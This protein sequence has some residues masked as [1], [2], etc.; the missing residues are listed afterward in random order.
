MHCVLLSIDFR[1]HIR[2]RFVKCL[3]LQIIAALVA[4]LGF[5]ANVGF[6]EGPASCL[7]G[8]LQTSTVKIGSLSI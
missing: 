4:H 1:A 8:S 3:E 5:V 2:I 7:V 6:H